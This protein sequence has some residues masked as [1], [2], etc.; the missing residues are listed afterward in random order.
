MV[1]MRTVPGTVNRLGTVPK[2]NAFKEAEAFAITGL[3][4]FLSLEIRGQSPVH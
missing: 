1:G 3:Q 2:L 4:P